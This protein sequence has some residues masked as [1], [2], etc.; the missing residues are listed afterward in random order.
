MKQISGD[1]NLISFCSGFCFMVLWVQVAVGGW[2]GWGEQSPRFQWVFC[3]V[4]GALS[5]KATAD[6]RAAL[7]AR[8]YK[9]LWHVE[10]R[11]LVLI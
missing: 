3:G 5:F 11:H 2:I 10:R 1:I 7:S 4:V 6:A 9:W 8:F